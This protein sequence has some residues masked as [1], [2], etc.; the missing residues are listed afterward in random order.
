MIIEKNYFLELNSGI[1]VEHPIN[2][3]ITNIDLIQEQIR[4]AYEDELRHSKNDIKVNGH[5]I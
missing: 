4:A 2:E 3:V 1:Q 5:A